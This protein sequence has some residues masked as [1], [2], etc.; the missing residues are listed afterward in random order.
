MRKLLLIAAL[1][2]A[3]AIA[4][5][6]A[7]AQDQDNDLQPLLDRVGRLERDMNVLERQVYRNGGGNGPVALAPGQGSNA[8]GDEM[9]FEQLGDQMRELTGRIE[10]MQH[11][12]DA[13][14]TRVN[15]VSGDVDMRLQALEQ[16]NGAAAATATNA[17]PPDRASPPPT[18]PSRNPPIAQNPPED[19]PQEPAADDQ[20]AMAAPPPPAPVLSET[21]SLPNGS[22]QQQY[23]YAFGLLRDANYPAAEMAL[24][25]F[26][27]RYPN[28][29]LVS[30]AQ[31][32]LGETYFVRGR[33]QAAA[34]AFAE[35]YQKFPKGAK[36]ADDLLKLGSALARLGRKADACRSFSQLDHSFPIAPANLKQKESQE[37]RQ[38][39]CG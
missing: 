17:P 3:S 39:G 6:G 15:K 33:F 35:G 13:L 29:A 1:V 14:K 26:V 4:A 25:D 10:E 38:A 2:A 36:A 37:K 34:A 5:H 11:D 21:G 32:W 24:R 27:G 30:N 20:Q 19:A 22:P 12:I 31:Y 7:I 23:D 18:R 8:A 28:N 16:G 9:R